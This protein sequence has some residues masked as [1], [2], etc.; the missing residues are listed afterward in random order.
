MRQRQFAPEAPAFSLIN[1]GDEI[2]VAPTEKKDLTGLTHGRK[3]HRPQLAGQVNCAVRDPGT[4]GREDRF[5]APFERPLETFTGERVVG[6]HGPALFLVGG[7][8]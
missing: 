5:F 7:S 4:M 1:V 2:C 8:A 3:T 6:I